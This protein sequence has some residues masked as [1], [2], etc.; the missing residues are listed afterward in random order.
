[1][2]G[3]CFLTCLVFQVEELGETWLSLVP[4]AL[5]GVWWQRHSW[6]SWL[7]R[8]QA[9]SGISSG[10]LWNW[11]ALCRPSIAFQNFLWC[12][13]QVDI[14]VNFCPCSLYSFLQAQPVGFGTRAGS[15][16]WCCLAFVSHH[17]APMGTH[18]LLVGNVPSHRVSGKPSSN[19]NALGY[20]GLLRGKLLHYQWTG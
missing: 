9:S 17:E 12:R 19:A 10:L 6:G 13:T 5:H 4:P 18:P 8:Q 11:K 16:W 1:M 14:H 7:Q 15:S 20:I 3:V 2:E